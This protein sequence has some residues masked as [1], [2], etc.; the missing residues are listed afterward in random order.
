VRRG[1]R[2]L[3]V[4]PCESF[5]SLFDG[6]QKVGPLVPMHCGEFDVSQTSF[7]TAGVDATI[8]GV[9]NMIGALRTHPDQWQLLLERLE[10]RR[11]ASEE[12]LRWDSAVQTAWTPYEAR[13]SQDSEADLAARVVRAPETPQR[14]QTAQHLQA[15]QPLQN[16]ASH[17]AVHV[18]SSPPPLHQASLHQALGW[19]SWGYHLCSAR[20]AE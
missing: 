13:R 7:L 15:V 17:S 14:L 3:A 2:S 9:G 16:W 8:N 4:D 12:A 6:S 20:N 11:R 1:R 19:R 5:A 18:A 10:L